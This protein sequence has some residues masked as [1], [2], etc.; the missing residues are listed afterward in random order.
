MKI[1][2]FDENKA[3]LQEAVK[4]L[5]RFIEAQSLDISHKIYAFYN[6]KAIINWLDDNIPDVAFIELKPTYISGS[7]RTIAKAIR[8]LSKLAHIIFIAEKIEQSIDIFYGLIRPTDF[9]LRPN[10]YESIVRIMRDILEDRK[11]S[12]TVIKVSYGKTT[13]MLNADDIFVIQKDGRKTQIN[14][15]NRQI[16]VV[17]TIKEIMP[18]LPECFVQVDKGVIVNLKMVVTVDFSE[19][20]LK[21]KNNQVIFVSRNTIKNVKRVLDKI[22][23]MI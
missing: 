5:N 4:C 13:Y 23:E 14:L 3:F 18:R 9:I 8:N 21:L 20:K 22:E 6:E 2:V 12:P 11:S 1:V 7:G 16:S 19:R 17:D 15:L 10:V